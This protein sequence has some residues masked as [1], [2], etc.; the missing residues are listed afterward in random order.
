[1]PRIS[2]TLLAAAALA[3]C[4]HASPAGAQV[5]RLAEMTA[6][7]VG[8]LDRERTVLI[9]PGS[10]LEEHG[11]YL[12]VYTDGYRNER[13]A[14]EVAAAVAAR[15]GWTAVVLPTVP[16][17]SGGFEGVAGRADYPGTVAVR[18][19]TLRSVFMDLADD[20]GAR[21][22]RRVFVVH[23]HGDPNHN[24]ALDLAGDYFHDTYGGFMV[25]L[26]GRR[27]CQAESASGA[28][29]ASLFGPEAAAADAG[30][31]HAGTLEF[32]RTLFLRPD[33]V[34]TAFVRAPDVTAADPGAWRAAA[35]RPDWPGYVG[36][37][38]FSS[39][40]LGRWVYANEARGCTALALRLLDG[41]D[42]RTVPRYADEMRAIPP[43]R[44]L[45]DG[46]LRDEEARAARQ[47]RW[48]ERAPKRP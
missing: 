12:P 43:V 8:R 3:A 11:P 20:I 9:I 5:L 1:M 37:P 23:G 27:G 48:L 33:L 15:P 19:A 22:F 17:G 29:P 35:A 28:P 45:V 42:E 21:G 10:I 32:S 39:W 24:R 25:H 44:E 40:E 13:I 31:P 7:Q 2:R 6:A 4:V 30:S 41:L 34:D 26:L 38:R 47:A 46:L 16:L 36:A 14:A 18:A